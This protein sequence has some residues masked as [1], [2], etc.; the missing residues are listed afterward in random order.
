MSS[1]FGL[2]LS[3]GILVMQPL[4]LERLL[5]LAVSVAAW[6]LISHRQPAFDCRKLL[7]TVSLNE[8][9]NKVH[10]QKHVSHEYFYVHTL[11]L[12]PHTATAIPLESGTIVSQTCRARAS[13]VLVFS[14][15][16][17]SAASS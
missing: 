1:A 8:T 15:S 14:C 13:S 17:R 4:C 11:V 10:K 6:S 12:T 3:S 2:Q 7:Q 5:R 16:S 9:I